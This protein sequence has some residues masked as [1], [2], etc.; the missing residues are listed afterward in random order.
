MVT[1]LEGEERDV[2]N[3]QCANFC[4][5][6]SSQAGYVQAFNQLPHHQQII[7]VLIQEEWEDQPHLVKY[8]YLQTLA[9]LRTMA[10]VWSADDALLTA[11]VAKVVALR[12]IAEF[13]RTRR[14][15]GMHKRM[16]PPQ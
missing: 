14:R 12:H 16:V 6:L 4:R 1:A 7:A 5:F 13:F 3:T 9:D 8:H 10:I 15:V 11:V 2:R